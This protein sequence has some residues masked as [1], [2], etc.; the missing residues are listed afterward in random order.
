MT[1]KQVIIS[2]VSVETEI[3][4]NLDEFCLVCQIAPEFVH[5]LVEYGVIEPQGRSLSMWRFN[6]DHLRRVRTVL[7]LQQDLEVNLSGAALVI[8]LMDEIEKLRA[9]VRL[10]ER[11][12]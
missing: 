3:E 7:H 9:Q 12:L 4:L 6:A 1:G 8:E 5:E 11:C 10:F 2:T